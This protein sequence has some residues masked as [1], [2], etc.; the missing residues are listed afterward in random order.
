[1]EEDL[2]N[3]ECRKLYNDAALGAST[4]DMDYEE[5]NNAIHQSGMNTAI[6]LKERCKG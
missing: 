1:L 3:D 4:V 5:F 6:S 2:I